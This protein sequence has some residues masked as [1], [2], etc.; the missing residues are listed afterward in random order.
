M[1][2]GP[3]LRHVAKQQCLSGTLPEELTP[4]TGGFIP[5]FSGAN[6]SNRLP[7][8]PFSSIFLPPLLLSG[9]LIPAAKWPANLARCSGSVGSC[10]VY[11][12]TKKV[13]CCMATIWVVF[14]A[15]ECSSEQKGWLFILHCASGPTDG[16]GWKNFQKR[17]I[18]RQQRKT[19]RET[20]TSGPREEDWRS[21]CVVDIT[22]YSILSCTMKPVQYTNVNLLSTMSIANALGR[23]LSSHT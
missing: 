23:L 6:H 13:I 11:F 7:S 17:K 1:L 3:P 2:M 9:F 20:S 4:D 15:P 16:C 12:E 18:L 21:L 5:P 22:L 10:L 19:P 8:V 14:R